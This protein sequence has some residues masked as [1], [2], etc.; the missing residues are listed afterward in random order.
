MNIADYLKNAKSLECETRALEC[1][2]S[3]IE[4]LV[5]NRMV[6]R[7]TFLSYLS[8][9]ADVSSRLKRICEIKEEIFSLIK[10]VDNPI[11]R[12]LLTLRYIKGETM[13]RCAEIM[14][15]EE[16]HIYRIHKKA[17]AE[18]EK[19]RCSVDGN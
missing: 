16:R 12:T 4:F 15:Y 6:S 5:K 1:T 9:K 3:D 13:E 2:L 8:L 7:D 14:E 18:A 10:K 17:L 11:Y 19:I